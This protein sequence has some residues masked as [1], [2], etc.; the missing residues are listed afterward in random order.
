KMFDIFKEYVGW[1]KIMNL[2]NVG[3]FNQSC[4]NN[5]TFNHIKVS[6]ALHEKK[7]AEIAEMVSKKSEKVRFVL[8]SGPSSSGK[9]TFSKRLSIQLMVCGLKPIV[10]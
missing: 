7:V 5:Q 1:N 3:D 6:E 10:L 9:T 2:N 4:R 8:V